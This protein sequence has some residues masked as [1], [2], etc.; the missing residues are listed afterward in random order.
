MDRKSK[1]YFG[2]SMSFDD[3]LEAISWNDVQFRYKNREYNITMHKSPCI[4]VINE[5]DEVWE[6][7]M[8]N[9]STYEELLLNHKFDDGISLLDVLKSEDI[10]T[11]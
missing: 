9:Y 6:N 1:L 2:K 8:R 10:E 4:T 3:V 5:T 7:C 11:C